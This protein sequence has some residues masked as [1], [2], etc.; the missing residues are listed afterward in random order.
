MRACAC[1]PGKTR[2][3]RESRKRKF[4]DLI[5]GANKKKRSNNRHRGRAMRNKML[6]DKQWIK[7]ERESRKEGRK[8][9]EGGRESC[10]VRQ[11]AKGNQT[12]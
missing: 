6:S 1:A 2:E 12:W 10:H 11:A 3:C 5:E 8:E 4:T 9:G 7:G